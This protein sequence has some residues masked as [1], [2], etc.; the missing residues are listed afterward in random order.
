MRPC[1]V[2]KFTDEAFGL[3]YH[4]DLDFIVSI[5]TVSEAHGHY[6]IY[7]FGQNMIYH[8]QS[9][10][11]EKSHNINLWDCYIIQKSHIKLFL[12]HMEEII[13][14]R[15]LTGIQI[16]EKSFFVHF[17]MIDFTAL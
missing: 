14:R 11:N 10:N 3:C 7:C 13:P 2:H 6:N 8:K 16:R 9:L 12:H 1:F 17:I 4:S 5:A 15:N